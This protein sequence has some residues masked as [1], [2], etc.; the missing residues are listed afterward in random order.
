MG[1]FGAA[2][3]AHVCL[4]VFLP[5]YRHRDRSRS[6]PPRADHD[7]AFGANFSMSNFVKTKMLPSTEDDVQAPA[8]PKSDPVLADS[9]GDPY[10]VIRAVSRSDGATSEELRHN[11]SASSLQGLEEASRNEEAA[12]ATAY[13]PEFEE[14]VMAAEEA[15]MQNKKWCAIGKLVWPLALQVFL[16]FGVTIALFPAVSV[17]LRYDNRLGWLNSLFKSCGD[18]TAVSPLKQTVGPHPLS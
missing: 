16:C 17:M 12:M 6:V 9:R 4:F 10:A 8:V 1:V 2:N 11:C 18:I 13:D 14:G 15:E 7:T 5:N 3:F